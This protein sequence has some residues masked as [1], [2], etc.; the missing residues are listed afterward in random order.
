MWSCLNEQI[1]VKF[2]NIELYFSQ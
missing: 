2:A 1:E